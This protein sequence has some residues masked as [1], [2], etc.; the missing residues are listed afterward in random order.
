MPT[1]R[2]VTPVEKAYITSIQ[3]AASPSKQLEL[4]E[5]RATWV[6]GAV[7]TVG[8]A[9][10]GF[11]VLAGSPTII[12]VLPWLGFLI[13][14]LTLVAVILAAWTLM[15]KAETLNPNDIGQVEG[16]F[17]RRVVWRTR[18][19]RLAIIALTVAILLGGVGAFFAA[20]G[21]N[22]SS[23]SLEWQQSTSGPTLSLS[24]AIG[25]VSPDH[26]VSAVLT[27]GGGTVPSAELYS[28][29]AQPD[30]ARSVSIQADVAVPPGRTYATLVLSEIS[31]RHVTQIDR[32]SV[33]IR[34]PSQAA[35][36]AA[37]AD[38][39]VSAAAASLTDLWRSQLSAEG[40]RQI[41]PP[42][43][44]PF[45]SRTGQYPPLCNR[46]LHIDV[47]ANNAFYCPQ[48]NYIAWDRA[49]MSQLYPAYG[50]YAVAAVIAHEWGHWVQATIG[51]STHGHLTEL[52]DD[53]FA[54]VWG[55]FAESG[56]AP[57]LH[58]QRAD[59]AD[60][61]VALAWY[62]SLPETPSDQSDER[63]ARFVAFLAGANNGLTACRK[64]G[65]LKPTA[66]DPGS[67]TG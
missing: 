23:I 33:P 48:A 31:G 12:D 29:R 25:D 62:R 6:F 66:D 55:N 49:L 24:V 38:Y 21:R 40:V 67:A 5:K 57:T 19:I 22:P 4:I 11:T 17:K 64:Y 32:L 28:A 61:L 56:G 1:G 30:K 53:C 34:T 42:R 63:N 43:M 3:D 20:A 44:I 27:A 36:P 2:V 7:G 14:G 51:R 10:T 45:D 60:A 8:V 15:I 35:T 46:V 13:V 39:I 18:F 47:V 37:S 26:T 54:G 58:I 52:Q 59:R 9:L 41:A 16:Y 65:A 50:P